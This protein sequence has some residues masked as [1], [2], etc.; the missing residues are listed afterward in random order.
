MHNK[1]PRK[2]EGRERKEIIFEEVITKNFH[3]CEKH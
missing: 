1:S 2:R 3:F